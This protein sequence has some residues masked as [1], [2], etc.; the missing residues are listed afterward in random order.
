[1]FRARLVLRR[2]RAAMLLVFLRMRD[3]VTTLADIEARKCESGEID[4]CQVVWPYANERDLWC[5]RCKALTAPVPPTKG[6]ARRK[7]QP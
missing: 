3:A 6:R 1:V 7:G 5:P 4:E 2:H